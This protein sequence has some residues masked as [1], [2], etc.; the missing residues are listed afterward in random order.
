MVNKAR[1]YSDLCVNYT[2]NMHLQP[3]YELQVP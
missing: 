1:L 2:F 3:H